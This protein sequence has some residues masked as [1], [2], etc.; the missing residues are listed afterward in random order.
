MSKYLLNKKQAILILLVFLF[1]FSFSKVDAQEKIENFQ[2]DIR[3]QKD[4]S[5]I[6]EENISYRFSD[7]K[8]NHGI[9][10]EIPLKFESDSE[11]K[12]INIEVLSVSKNGSTEPYQI[13]DKGDILNI[14][15]GDPNK[16]VLGIENY[17]INYKVEGALNYLENKNELYWDVT[18]N[19][20]N[21]S[22]ENVDTTVY[23]PSKVKEN[24]LDLFCYQ[25]RFKSSEKCNVNKVSGEVDK[26]DFNS[27][28]TLKPREG[29]TVAVG[30]PKNMVDGPGFLSILS[31]WFSDNWDWMFFVFVFSFMFWRW[32]M[33]GKDPE[34][35]PITARYSPPEGFSPILVGSIIDGRVH[36]RDITA[37][38]IYLAQKGVISIERIESTTLKI[39]N[40]VDYKLKIKNST[41]SLSKTEENILNIFFGNYSE[42]GDEVLISDIKNNVNIDD[43][44]NFLKKSIHEK[45]VNLG[46]FV[47]SPKKVR[48]YYLSLGITLFIIGSYLSVLFIGD[49]ART[50][51][52]ILGSSLVIIVFSYLMPKAT[53]EGAKV[54]SHILGFKDFL[55]MTQK[56]RLKFHNSADKSPEEFMEYLPYAIALGVEDSWAKQFEDVYI[57]SPSWY[58]GDASRSVA[59]ASLASQISNFSQSTGR[60][61][62]SA[63][64]KSSSG[65]SGS[66]SSG[67][68]FSGGGIGGG[69]GG[70]W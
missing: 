31:N 50:V 67:G 10:R 43:K 3:I 26:I 42:Q 56:E 53:K 59:A 64:S 4:S 12:T 35:G 13:T 44:I 62:Y 8:E 66:G 30:F 20:W 45:M 46:L 18:G 28:R 25:G 68:G 6:V 37:G 21:L 47:K 2:S 49:S 11:T 29:L 70:S 40:N 19:D 14:K 61:V 54:K 27:T 15:I 48:N 63:S 60:S 9:F 22:I 1:V 34:I 7:Q 51:I 16:L 24:N 58:S 69:G 52:S 39:F 41:D 57:N 5:L 36:S 32:Y 17:S 33:R 65:F 38:L 23:L 55:S